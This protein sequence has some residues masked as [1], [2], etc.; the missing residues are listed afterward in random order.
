METGP[1]NK[2]A[3]QAYIEASRHPA[4][5][6]AERFFAPGATIHMVHPFNDIDGPE[7]YGPAFL[8]PLRAAF[9]GLCRSDYIAF[10]GR[11][12]GADW[13]TC[14]GI[15]FLVSTAG[16]YFLPVTFW[17][18]V[19]NQL[20][21]KLACKAQAASPTMRRWVSRQ[22]S[23]AGGSICSTSRFSPPT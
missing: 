5:G 20:T 17:P 2:A 14:T 4:E 12:D 18:V 22:R 15:K 11:Y 8:A 23:K 19:L 10:G 16:K 1:R 13:V 6:A 7:N 9:E 21:M 3:L